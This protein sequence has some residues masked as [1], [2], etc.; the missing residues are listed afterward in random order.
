MKKLFN[1][2]LIIFFSF[3][4]VSLAGPLQDKHKMVIGSMSSATPDWA[5][6]PETSGTP[7]TVTGNWQDYANTSDR[8]YCTIWTATENGTATHV[9]VRYDTD[10]NVGANGCYLVLYN[11]TDLIGYKK[12]TPSTSSWSGEVALTEDSS[13]SLAFSTNDVLRFGIAFD[14][15][16]TDMSISYDDGLSGD[17]AEYDN[18]V[19]G[20]SAP[21]TCSW[22]TSGTAHD[23]AAILRYNE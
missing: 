12:V 1:L 20:A 13:G 2:I 17:Y 14:G 5:G 23:I 11:G 19:V 22:S 4:S 16:G 15:A 21:A 10:V 7:A 6:Y 8:E 18:E 9:N 3:C